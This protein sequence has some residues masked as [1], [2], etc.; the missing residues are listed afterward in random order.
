MP[1][2]HPAYLLRTP[3]A[4][5]QAWQDLQAVLAELA[6]IGV[7]PPSP[8]AHLSASPVEPTLRTRRQSIRH[9]L[10]CLIQTSGL[11]RVLGGGQRQVIEIVDAGEEA[12][13]VG[14]VGEPEGAYVEVV[15]E[16]VQQAC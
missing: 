11:R 4:K 6:K 13:G 12:A 14:R 10:P 2:Y 1:T 15:A 5:R 7:V 8:P 16:L 3:E 9:L